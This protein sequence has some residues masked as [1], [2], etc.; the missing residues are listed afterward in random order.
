M[1]SSQKG[2]ALKAQKVVVP[3][4]SGLVHLLTSLTLFLENSF[5][6]SKTDSITTQQGCWQEKDAGAFAAEGSPTLFFCK[7]MN[8]LYQ[9]ML[10]I[11]TCPPLPGRQ[12]RAVA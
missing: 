1:V 10:S 5:R 2:P 9:V 4:L 3:L 7:F 8:A 11:L 6:G 12:D